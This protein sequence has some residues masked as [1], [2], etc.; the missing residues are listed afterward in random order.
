MTS[1][2]SFAGFLS[3][4]PDLD[5]SR[6]LRFTTLLAEESGRLGGAAKALFDHLGDFGASAR[7]ATPAHEVDD[8]IID[9]GNYFAEL[10]SL[11]ETVRVRLASEGI[12]HE[13]ALAAFLDDAHAVRVVSAGAGAA[14]PGRRGFA[15]APV[16]PRFVLPVR[17]APPHA[18]VPLHRLLL[19][20]ARAAPYARL[21]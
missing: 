15:F 12:R 1:I 18:S 2:R 21:L 4:H 11:A 6:R 17:A 13:A 10:E 14:P 8:F 9:R 3:E 19:L 20:L 7:P 5:D 16:S